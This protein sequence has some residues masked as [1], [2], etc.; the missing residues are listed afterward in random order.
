MVKSPVI[1]VV[2]A[3]SAASSNAASNVL[4]R[5]ADRDEPQERS[6]SLRMIW[7]LLHRKQWL[8]GSACVLGSFF[9]Q[10]GALATGELALVQPIIVL[11]LPLTI[12]TAKFALGAQLRLPDWAA[13]ALLTTG[14]A[15]F[16]GSLRPSGGSSTAP[17]T[18][19][20]LGGGVAVLAIG[21]LVLI[22]RGHAGELR[23]GLLGAAAGLSF[24]TT[25]AFMKA[26]TGLLRA[27]VLALFTSWPVYCMVLMGALGMFLVQ[28]AFQAG[29]LMASQPGI[30]LLDPFSATAWGIFAFDERAQGGLSLALAAISGAVMAVGAV[31]LS[32]SPA[33]QQPQTDERE[34]ARKRPT[35]HE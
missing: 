27:G 12:I 4:Q 29:K 30:S 9:F 26:A 33:L 10:A 31:M 21:T 2:L 34:P 14:L 13:I 35:A 15:G 8:L 7:D 5:V 32:R 28:N 25:A 17:G 3:L 19:W 1:S 23:A 11:E 22:G 6:F 16:V 20:A 24:G 18:V